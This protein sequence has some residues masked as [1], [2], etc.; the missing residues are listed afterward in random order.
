MV[1]EPSLSKTLDDIEGR[2]HGLEVGQKHLI[3]RIQDHREDFSAFREELFAHIHS[4][5]KETLEKM[6]SGAELQNTRIE[7]VSKK[8]DG[9]EAKI[10]QIL[11]ALPSS[12]IDTTPG[13]GF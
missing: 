4:V 13:S 2:L 5:R 8:L 10:N 11:D 6:E 7:Q 1:A 9:L 12:D 3:G